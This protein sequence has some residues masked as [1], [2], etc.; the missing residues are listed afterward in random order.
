MYVVQP[1]YSAAWLRIPP[2]WSPSSSCAKVVWTPEW[3]NKTF[4][5]PRNHEMPKVEDVVNHRPAVCYMDD[6][7]STWVVYIVSCTRKLF[8]EGDLRMQKWLLCFCDHNGY[9]LSDL[10]LWLV[11]ATRH[12]NISIVMAQSNHQGATLS[13]RLCI[14]AVFNFST[15][16]QQHS[17]H[18]RFFFPHSRAGAPYVD[19]RVFIFSGPSSQGWTLSGQET[20]CHIQ[21]SQPSYVPVTCFSCC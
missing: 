8:K 18:G 12:S 20:H 15:L 2:L 1:V 7:M 4:L 21:P 6:V 11:W 13:F 9:K 19:L 16:F 17:G 5:W 14:F 3:W 10:F